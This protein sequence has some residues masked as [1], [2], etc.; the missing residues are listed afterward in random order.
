M[1]TEQIRKEYLDFIAKSNNLRNENINKTEDRSLIKKS[2]RIKSL[3]CKKK[4][5]RKRRS[6]PKK[7]KKQAYDKFLQSAKW[8]KIR[9]IVMERDYFTCQMCG[10]KEHLTVHHKT[11]VHHG[12]EENHLGDLITW[13]DTCHKKFHSKKTIHRM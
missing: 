6:R 10:S 8:K 5:L 13:C 2:N 12:D 9:K 7:F 11:Y 3:N 1:N 4:R